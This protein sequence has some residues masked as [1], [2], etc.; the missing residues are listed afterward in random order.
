LESSQRRG[1]AWQVWALVA[2]AASLA[3]VFAVLGSGARAA[4]ED[5]KA[6]FDQLCSG[7]HTIGGG[8]LV[9]PDLQGLADRRERDWIERFIREPDAVIASGDP[10]AKQLLD[11]Y[12]APMPNLGV[13]DAQLSALVAFLGFAQQTPPETTPTETTP[14][15]PAPAPLGDPDRGKSLF[16]GSNR[17]DTGG[18]AC[19]SCHSVAGLGALGGGQLG[20]D[21]TGAFDK[22]GGEQ[23]MQAVLEA[24]AFPTMAPIFADRPLSAEERADLVAFLERAADEERGTGQAGK[25]V[26]LALGVAGVGVLLA[27]VIWRRRLRGV[28]RS[29]VGRA[30]G[31][32]P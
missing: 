9:G 18:P 11:E 23:G 30:T 27:L 12:G 26:A 20:P 6:I 8:T 3:A 22:Y 13:S 16:E 24:V 2:V 4:D 5:G 28:R 32:T 29:L 10:I 7:C 31:G 1:T 15:E 21:L 17:F 25:L 19:L 14:T